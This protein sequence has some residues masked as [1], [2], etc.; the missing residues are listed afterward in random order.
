MGLSVRFLAVKLSKSKAMNLI[1][2]V[3]LKSNSVLHI[4]F[5]LKQL[6]SRVLFHLIGLIPFK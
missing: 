5:K 4:N 3:L 6:L 2:L 1:P